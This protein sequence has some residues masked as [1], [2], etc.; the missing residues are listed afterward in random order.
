MAKTGDFTN[1][2]EKAPGKVVGEMAI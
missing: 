1:N 2:W